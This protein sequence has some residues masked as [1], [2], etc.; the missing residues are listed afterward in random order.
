ML[1]KIHTMVKVLYSILLFPQIIPQNF[2]LSLVIKVV[3]I[4]F[5]NLSINLMNQRLMSYYHADIRLILRI[6]RQQ[7]KICTLREITMK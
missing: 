4:T 7:D 1:A 3:K 2:F 6:Q 5:A